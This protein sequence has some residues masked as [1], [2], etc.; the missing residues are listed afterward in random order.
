MRTSTAVVV[1]LG[2][3][4]A[5]VIGAWLSLIGDVDPVGPLAA[6]VREEMC[7]ASEA[8]ASR[9]LQDGASTPSSTT[10]VDATEPTPARTA[11]PRPRIRGRLIDRSTGGP[12]AGWPIEL[13]ISFRPRANDLARIALENVVFNLQPRNALVFAHGET[14]G[15]TSGR[16]QGGLVFN[17]LSDQHRLW[18]VTNAVDALR[19]TAEQRLGAAQPSESS[20]PE[21]E[22][23]SQVPPPASDESE[24]VPSSDAGADSSQGSA[25]PQSEAQETGSLQSGIFNL[26]R[27]QANIT[28]QPESGS[29]VTGNGAAAAGELRTVNPWI[30]FVP[31]FAGTD[32]NNRFEIKVGGTDSSPHEL[33]E[34]RERVNL[35]PAYL[36]VLPPT[37]RSLVLSRT[38]TD[39]DGWFEFECPA[40]EDQGVWLEAPIFEGRFVTPS[41]YEF[42]DRKL[43]CA[44]EIVWRTDFL[45]GDV[46]RGRVIDERTREPVPQLKVHL[47]ALLGREADVETDDEGR[48]ASTEALPAGA[49]DVRFS[50]GEDDVV[51][52]SK[53]AEVAFLDKSAPA[54]EVLFQIAI[55]P[56]YRFTLRLDPS[57]PVA[58]GLGRA[59]V[60][61]SLPEQ[62]PAPA[63]TAV[64][65]EH[66]IVQVRLRNLV[67]LAHDELTDNP[68][69]MWRTLRDETPCRV[70]YAMP[71][72]AEHG[73]P[74]RLEVRTEG[75][76]YA[77]HVDVA[78]TCGVSPRVLDVLLATA[79]KVHG[80]V[81]DAAGEGIG[82]ATIAI[83]Y[84]GSSAGD[85]LDRCL[86]D[87]SGNFS[88]E[89][90]EPGTVRA[91]EVTHP[92]HG[93]K[94]IDVVL[95]SEDEI[96]LGDD[97]EID[98]VL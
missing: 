26:I 35:L 80:R 84:A 56:T 78:S 47:A 11:P 45:R 70:R 32:A 75:K 12:I 53:P 7:D 72:R 27:F 22:P 68:F 15:L 2:T 96:S 49:I 83:V 51:V 48:F 41:K 42:D 58:I 67:P 69:A 91:I 16:N 24:D 54:E 94:V 57:S 97:F 8:Q 92:E 63:E 61:G 76:D 66:V 4:G 30:T 50:D 77:G 14:L 85:V 43:A 64:S 60:P 98:V 44:E 62:P 10:L 39:A 52:E 87:F 21:E 36:P 74:V 9:A 93:R 82:D 1:A 46:F 81:H 29:I 86:T 71:G 6:S 3:A 65:F 20:A 13:W 17:Y 37:Y 31:S 73:G 89:G 55:G 5:I 40:D 19:M 90:L 34:L 28:L 88:F 25:P 79:A 95:S 38:T 18:T 33:E 59:G 23:P